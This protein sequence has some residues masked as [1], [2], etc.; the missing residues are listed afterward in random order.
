MAEKVPAGEERMESSFGV[1]PS[2][3]RGLTA[4]GAPWG[5]RA[6]LRDGVL[7]CPNCGSPITEGCVVKV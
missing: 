1:P 4:C 7:V 5:T 2:P 6:E 3:R